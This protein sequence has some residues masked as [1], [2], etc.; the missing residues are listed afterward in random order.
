MG[1][2]RGKPEVS[3]DECPMNVPFSFSKEEGV[4]GNWNGIVTGPGSAE[5]ANASA[6][7]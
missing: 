5:N 2:G 4:P 1:M 3:K 7:F 6:Q